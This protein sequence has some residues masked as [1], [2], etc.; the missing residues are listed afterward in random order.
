MPHIVQQL[1]AGND[2]LRILHEILKQ[3]DLVCSKR[4]RNSI[5][6]NFHP[7]KIGSDIA[8][9]ARLLFTATLGSSDCCLNAGHQFARAER[10]R[11][12]VIRA[13]LQQENLVSNLG[14]STQHDHRCIRQTSS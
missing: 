3:F 4:N 7:G 1:F 11:H 6:G 8:K 12:I 14:H 9:A 2:A 13:H 10:F 5:S